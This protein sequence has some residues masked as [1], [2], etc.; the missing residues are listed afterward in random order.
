M[1][2]TVDQHAPANPSEAK[3]ASGRFARRPTPRLWAY[4]LGGDYSV[5]L[6]RQ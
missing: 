2:P 5:S 1:V 3:R 6:R 4:W